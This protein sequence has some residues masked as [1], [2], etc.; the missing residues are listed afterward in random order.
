MAL[1]TAPSF[2][3][4]LQGMRKEVLDRFLAKVEQR[5]IA[6]N[7]LAREA[8]LDHIPQ[9]IDEVLDRL[10]RGDPSYPGG[11]YGELETARRH[12][13]NRWALG[14][15][16]TSLIREY[17]AL[18]DAIFEITSEGGAEVT[19]RDFNVFA[20]WITVGA[21]AAVAEYDRR[22][23]ERIQLAYAKLAE[24][25]GIAEAERRR[26]AAILEI[27]PIGLV[28]SDEAGRVIHT[29]EAD[30]RL[31]GRT[32]NA[33]HG[34]SPAWTPTAGQRVAAE[35][36]AL[37]RSLRTG[38]IVQREEVEIVTPNGVS[39]T[40]LISSAPI[41]DPSGTIAGAVG[42][43][44]DIT[45]EKESLRKARAAAVVR[46]E[47]IAVVS[48]D[49]RD[50]LGV[51]EGNAVYIDRML[52]RGPLDVEGVKRRLDAI[53]RSSKRM[54]RLVSDLLDVTRIEGGKLPLKR[55]EWSVEELIAQARDEMAPTAAAKSIDLR[56][57]V[58]DGKRMVRCDRNRV[59]Q[60]F[61]NLVGNSVQFTP[62][63]GAVTIG[64]QDL[65]A[66][67]RFHVRDTGVGIHPKQLPHIFDRFWQERDRDRDRR[68]TG[69][70]LTIAKG[71][72]ELHG[73]RIWVE[74]ELGRG[75]TVYFTLPAG[76]G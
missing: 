60:V 42:V 27:L 76:C 75:T 8:I 3:A 55:E 33:H 52:S 65:K 56:T 58:H 29:N 21:A 38:E 66:E 70:G 14:Y 25:K 9:F 7:A 34:D 46:D 4:V 45:E 35:Q 44:V 37:S 1:V 72:V 57:E 12:A 74:S 50:P 54:E 48:H 67:Y 15:P 10:E 64:A 11:T 22:Q 61:A 5:K 31:W 28:I 20:N 39:K 68:G 69:L 36:R 19:L 2:H 30:E 24:E 62:E 26:L 51:V 47:I 23:T 63:G 40:L 6:P 17:G 73:G 71:I 41:R 16:L 43:N 13:S 53:R 18:R 49:L 32:P 59:L